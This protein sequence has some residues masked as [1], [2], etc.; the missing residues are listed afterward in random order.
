[1]KV[2]HW[3]DV[4]SD[5]AVAEFVLLALITV[6]Q[7]THRRIRGA[8]WLALSLILVG[9][10]SLAL[11]VD[12]GLLDDRNITKAFVALFLLVPYCVFRFTAALR[13]PGWGVEA[14]AVALTGATIGLTFWLNDVPVH[15]APAPAH[16]VVYQCAFLVAFALEFGY[17][18]V[19]L[20]VAA[21]GAPLLAG[22]RMRILSAAL[23]GLAMPVVV[24]VMR[25]E[26]PNVELAAGAVTVAMGV[27]L[28]IALVP[29]LVG[30]LLG[31]HG[32]AAFRRALDELVSAGESE[33]VAVSVL[34]HVAAL[35][36]ASEVALVA[37]DGTVLARYPLWLDRD[38][39]DLWGTGHTP[40]SGDG[41][42][43]RRTTR[44]TT[45]TLVV[46]ISGYLTYF[47]T[48]ELEQLEEL[49]DLAGR[50]IGRCETAEQMAFQ[51]S[52]D[53]LTGLAN[54]S[55][56]MERLDE[57]LRHVGRRRASLAVLFIDLD[58]F[59]LVNDRADH[60]A[61]D[62][63]LNE[64]ADRMTT[65]TRGVDVVA[66]FGGDEFV[67]LA[68]V[69]HEEHARDMAERIRRGLAAPL[70]VADSRLV[71]TASIGVVVTADP[72][73]TAAA[74]LRDADD[75]MYEAKRAGRDLVVVH[76]G[77]AREAAHHRWGMP[78]ARMPR[79]S[80]G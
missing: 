73:L 21:G 51:A 30:A 63:V 11:R 64:M 77:T 67:A 35:V 16:L 48:A 56:F 18:V 74:V 55:L 8:G 47:G 1:M 50:A 9:G 20:L 39:R 15:G 65:M 40:R 78:A 59:K 7:W 2:A 29:S 58:R 49:A 13:R 12:P 36:G 24:A 26:G 66:R 22:W 60:A 79:L 62:R 31:A 80:A 37:A 41:E 3:T 23:V 27:L 4:L 25:I 34:P 10:L 42:V 57:A 38:V 19:R 45:H 28:G 68:E 71:V 5:V 69:D 72:S 46:R 6:W 52:H 17:V 76:H 33:E 44:S 70:T 14:A 43:T 75:A 54:R 32:T 61:G 53:G